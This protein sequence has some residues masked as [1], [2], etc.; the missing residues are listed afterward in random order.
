MRTRPPL[1]MER[2][3]LFGL[4]ARTVWFARPTLSLTQHSPLFAHRRRMLTAASSWARPTA[5]IRRAAST[6][7]SPPF[8]DPTS[9]VCFPPLVPCCRSFIGLRGSHAPIPLSAF[10]REHR[11]HA[12]QPEEQL[13]PRPERA[14]PGLPHASSVAHVRRDVVFRLAAF[15][16]APS[17][18]F[19]LSFIDSSRRRLPRRT[20]SSSAAR[21]TPR[22]TPPRGSS[23]PSS[24]PSPRRRAPSSSTTPPTPS[25]STGRSAP[26]PSTRSRAPATSPSR[27][28]PSPST[29]GSRA[30][31]LGGRWCRTRSSTRTAPR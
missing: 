23:S 16:A 20:S 22:A 8:R 14:F 30:S 15:N 4:H 1:R 18:P 26:R 12:V 5:S 25:T 19:S 29:L 31:A 24:S 10:G 3:A 13:L 21:T 9:P 11:V 27:R 6:V 2:R 7:R 28:A 17:R